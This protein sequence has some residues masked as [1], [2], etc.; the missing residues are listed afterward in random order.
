MQAI[1]QG[2][3]G[4]RMIVNLRSRA[5]AVV[6]CVILT[7]TAG[8]LARDGEAPPPAEDTPILDPSKL[9]A[10]DIDGILDRLD[11]LYRSKSSIAE[12]SLTVT[13]PRRKRTLTMKTWSLGKDKAL[14]VIRAPAREKGVATLK[15]DK[16]L[17][18]YL[19]RTSRTIRIP[20]SMMLGSWMGS[21]FTNDDLVRDS[22]LRK[23]FDSRLI[24]KSKDPVGWKIELQA[25]EGTVGLWDRIQYII[26][27]DATLPLQAEYYDRKGRLARVMDFTDIKQFGK[28]KI[29]SRMVLTPIGKNGKPE[30][31]RKTELLYKNIKFDANVPEST[32]SLSR[33]ERGR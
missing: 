31:G 13:K 30:K 17:W 4:S 12:V 6:A 23:D 25:K 8:A 24:G 33:L 5:L 27:L 22:S 32:F 10:E 14:I 26:T 7:G 21:D 11:D 29:P 15:V 19:P 9:A 28:R 20:P 1:A 3:E 2:T 18:N 16:N